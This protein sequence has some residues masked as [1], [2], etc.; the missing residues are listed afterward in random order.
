[1]SAALTADARSSHLRLGAQANRLSQARVFVPVEENFGVP[2]ISSALV[3]SSQQRHAPENV[4]APLLLQRH[5]SAKTALS[6]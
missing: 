4:G 2:L 6:L 1:M 3:R 5:A